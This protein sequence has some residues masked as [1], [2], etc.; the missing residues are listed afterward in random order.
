VDSE[1]VSLA[2]PHVR[3]VSVPAE[4]RRLGQVYAGFMILIVEQAQLDARGGFR[5]Q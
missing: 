1:A 5:K 3:Q 2:G 4:C